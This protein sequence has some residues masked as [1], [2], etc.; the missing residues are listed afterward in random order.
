MSNYLKLKTR[1]LEARRGELLSK[2]RQVAHDL[3]QLSANLIAAWQKNDLEH[4]ASKIGE[5]SQRLEQFET[6]A[7]RHIFECDIATSIA[8]NLESGREVVLASDGVENPT[9]ERRFVVEPESTRWA[10]NPEK[11]ERATVGYEIAHRLA[12][13]SF[14]TTMAVGDS[15][16]ACGVTIR[17]VK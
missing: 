5:W 4:C 9:D 14:V 11:P 13:D 12:G 7:T 10:K 8:A 6:D 17:R 16:G 3:A 2:V 1:L 15:I